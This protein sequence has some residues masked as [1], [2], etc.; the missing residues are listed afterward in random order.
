[1]TITVK[2]IFKSL[3][4]VKHPENKSDIVALGMVQEIKVEKQ[5]VSFTL[6]FKT[7]SDPTIN[8]IRQACVKQLESD[9]ESIEIRGNIKIRA[10]KKDPQLSGL[11]NVKNIVAVVSGK[12]GVGKSTVAVNLAISLSQQGYKVGILDADVYG[13]S[14]PKMFGLETERPEVKSID[15]RNV[16]YPL[17]KYGIKAISLGFFVDPEQP[18][19]WRGPM[20]TSAI[21]QI[22]LEPEWGELDYL[23]MDMPPGTGDIHLTTV[24]T[25]A[26]T[27][28]VV[29][30]T[31]QKVAIADVIKG[32]NMFRSSSISVPILGL[33]ANMAWFTPEEFPN[34]R[35]YIFGKGALES[36]SEQF[37]I[38]ILGQIP[39]VESIAT[40]SDNGE[41]PALKNNLVGKSFMQL[42]NNVVEA[43][44]HRIDKIA[45]TSIVDIK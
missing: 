35:Y 33:V 11:E 5:K 30:S 45:P 22:L 37:N 9:F 43:V 8:Q 24:Q 16:I 34:N 29:V 36:V 26:L 17:E 6:I 31:P 25:V 42:A 21:K 27:G 10:L 3:Q 2:A 15:G 20:A 32:I 4:E 28:V 14:L 1:M 41:P 40:D 23:I 7:N 18:L 13:P 19:M 12:G 38:P 39:I 44:T